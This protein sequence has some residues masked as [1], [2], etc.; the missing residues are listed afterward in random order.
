MPR[1]QGSYS[2]RTCTSVHRGRLAAGTRERPGPELPWLGNEGRLK[3]IK[4]WLRTYQGIDLD[5]QVNQKREGQG[6]TQ[7]QAPI[8]RTDFTAFHDGVVLQDSDEI[9]AD[10][11]D[12][13]Q[14]RPTDSVV[15]PSQQHPQTRS[16]L[17]DSRTTRTDR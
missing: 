9:W 13:Y 7:K 4:D 2:A 16:T 15:T 12:C 14:V 8:V 6:Q 10:W 3:G 1:A 17:R 5:G 11:E